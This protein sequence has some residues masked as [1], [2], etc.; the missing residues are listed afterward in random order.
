[1][2]ATSIHYTYMAN[3]QKYCARFNFSPMAIRVTKSFRYPHGSA[4]EK[5]ARAYSEISPYTGN[6]IFQRSIR[7]CTR[8][9]VLMRCFTHRKS[10]EREKIILHEDFFCCIWWHCVHITW[11]NEIQCKWASISFRNKVYPSV[12]HESPSQ[13]V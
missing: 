9:Y 8:L 4:I 6:N 11:H 5:L 12:E 10:L 7:G 1:M 3:S 13:R 2:F